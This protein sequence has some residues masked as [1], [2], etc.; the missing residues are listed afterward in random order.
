M[1][2]S[3]DRK[4]THLDKHIIFFPFEKGKKEKKGKTEDQTDKQPQLNKM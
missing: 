3:S 2:F 1:P 4:Y